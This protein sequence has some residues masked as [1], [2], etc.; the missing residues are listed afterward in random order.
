MCRERGVFRC[1]KLLL[2]QYALQGTDSDLLASTELRDSF[3]RV[4]AKSCQR[5][6]RDRVQGCRL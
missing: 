1:R 2:K 4:T 6:L 3:I 5:C